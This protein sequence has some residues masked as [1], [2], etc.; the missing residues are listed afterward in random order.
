[1]HTE[2]AA[3]STN[4]PSVSRPA[5]S[6]ECVIQKQ[7]L[8]GQADDPLEA[9][10]DALAEHVMRMPEAP[11]I[12]RKCA[13][14]EEEQAIRRN[15]L[16]SSAVP[17]L[18]AK[19]AR[20][21]AVASTPIAGAIESSRGGGE[22]L[23]EPARTFMESRFDR[24]FSDVRIHRDTDAARLSEDLNAKA[25]TVGRDIYFGAGRFAPT[26]AEGKQL[27][28]H[29]LAH[30]T[31]QTGR[32]ERRIQR[33]CGETDIRKAVGGRFTHIE[34]GDP[35]VTGTL[36][37]FHVGC[38]EFLSAKDEAMLRSLPSTL[39]AR[40]RITIHG[41]ASE[42]GS[43]MFNLLLSQARAEKARD[44]LS[45]LLDPAQIERVVMHGAVPG[46]RKDRRAVVIEH[47]APLPVVTKNLTVV[48]W[49]NP[50]GLPGFSK[51]ALALDPPSIRVFEAACMAL[52]CTANKSPPKSLPSSDVPGFVGS[53]E[54]RGFQSY[55]L[56]V[57]PS[58][59]A[60][61]V[62]VPLQ[63]VG[64]TAPSSCEDIPPKTYRQG[65][66]SPL[67][68]ATPKMSATEAA[69]TAL[70]KFRVSAAEESAAIDEATSFPGS[71]LFSKKMLKH[72]P[73]VWT[74][75]NLRLDAASGL[76]HWSVQGSAFPT[77]TIYLDGVRVGEI[78]QG[79]CGVVVSSRF[80][81]ADQPR[82]TMAEEEAQRGQPLSKQEE[83]VDAGGTAS[84]TG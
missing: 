30:V 9:E 82:Q 19:L 47:A 79:P 68:H 31:Q 84:G 13:A 16:A 32:V 58:T 74:V 22:T 49:I 46:A 41:F 44:I 57:I 20:S 24:D 2:P 48:S 61:G 33:A 67:N 65:E 7:L 39:P 35:G 40:A 52:G 45:G 21:T 50:A 34:L 72:V 17:F 81:S 70:M 28:A 60:G 76:L 36:I 66:T 25:F 56:T 18:Q 27:L 55:S 26:A 63:I 59:T 62:L 6:P 29:E 75:T 71:L 5:A 15:P 23:P 73:W 78:P 11:L 42:E 64:Y 4:K 14:C 8:V 1:M 69:A 54:F 38:D 12:Q 10:A 83:T 53:K 51:A 37:H 80:R 3:V 43:P 77:H